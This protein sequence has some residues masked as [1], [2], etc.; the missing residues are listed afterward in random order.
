MKTATEAVK[1]LLG[2]TR[3]N[4]ARITLDLDGYNIAVQSNSQ[5][6][7]DKLRHY[8]GHCISLAEPDCLIIAINGPA[9]DLGVEF[10]DW[11]REPGKSGRKDAFYDLDDARLVQKV[12]TGMVFLQSKGHLIASGPSLEN[13]NQVINYINAQ[14]MNVLQQKGALICHASGLVRNG[15]CLGMAGFSGGGKSTLMLKMLEEEGLSYLTNDRLF[16]QG[17]K[18]T[19]IPK[20]PRINPGTILNNETLRPMLSDGRAAELKALPIEELWD[21]EEKYDVMVDEVYGAGKITQ[22]AELGAFLILNWKRDGDEPL[23]IKQVD[24][25]ERPELLHKAIMKSPGP[26]YQYGDGSF[27][28][29]TTE[30]DDQPYLETLANIP[31]FEASGTVDFEGAARFCL[32]E[33]SW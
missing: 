30:L 20:L 27:F 33:M 31:I 15:K 2:A 24:L 1:K 22:T 5:E 17:K 32:E 26:F 10:I 16:I 19:G 28:M 7:L 14:Y 29:D 11:K 23:S 21:L 4:P 18:A 3:I 13:D 12:R 9:P 25:T 6:L 8:F